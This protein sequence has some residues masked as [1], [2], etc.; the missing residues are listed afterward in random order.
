MGKP[1]ILAVDGE[2][3]VP[4]AIRRD[5]RRGCSSGNRVARGT[6]GPE[7]LDVLSQ[8]AL[9]GQRVALIV[10][11]QRMPQKTAIEG[12]DQ[13]HAHVRGENYPPV[14]AYADTDVASM[15]RVASA[16]GEGAMSVHFVHRYLATI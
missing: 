11:D 3:E 16:V 10:A 1:A 4:A 8:L 6:S 5:L 7:A 15:K 2:P 13:A 9:R 14:T 12:P